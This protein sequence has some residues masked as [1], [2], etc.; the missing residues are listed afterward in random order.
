[1]TF[2]LEGSMIFKLLVECFLP[3]WELKKNCSVSHSRYLRWIAR[4]LYEAYQYEN[5]SSISWKSKF[6][7]EPC[8]PHGMKSIFISGD[9]VIGSNCVIFQQVV[10]GSVV[11]PDSEKSG[12]PIIGDNCYIGAGAKIV[13]SVRIG[14][15]VRI[16]ANAVVFKDVPDNSVVVTGEQRVIIK[17]EKLDNNFY[18]N[19]ESW[20]YFSSGSWLEV[21]KSI[22][23][24]LDSNYK[25]SK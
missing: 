12:A 14:S 7:G 6:S 24:K 1:M 15:N 21:E 25:A 19:P 23:D 11:L 10:I 18:A 22:K 2:I 3:V 4:K 13:G 16:G 5:C 17:R 9:A 20:K 8:F